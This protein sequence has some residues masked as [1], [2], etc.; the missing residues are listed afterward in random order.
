MSVCGV[1]HNIEVRFLAK[2]ADLSEQFFPC[3]VFWEEAMQCYTPFFAF[4]FGFYAIFRLWKI[5]NICVYLHE[6]AYVRQF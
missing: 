5:A 1:S 2:V 4:F 3:K 6:N